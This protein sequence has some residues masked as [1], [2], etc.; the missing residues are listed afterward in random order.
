MAYYIIL[1]NENASEL[2][3]LCYQKFDHHRA[4]YCDAIQLIK[5]MHIIYHRQIAEMK[6]KNEGNNVIIAFRA[7]FATVVLKISTIS[8]RSTASY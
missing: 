8:T 2:K 5:L 4:Y 6:R 7:S 1:F 3:T